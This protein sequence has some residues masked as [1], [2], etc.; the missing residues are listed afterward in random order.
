MLREKKDHYE[1]REKN[2]FPTFS[3]IKHGKAQQ[4]EENIKKLLQHNKQY[5]SRDIFQQIEKSGRKINGINAESNNFELSHLL[6]TQ[7]IQPLPNIFLNWGQ[8]KEIDVVSFESLSTFFYDI[9]Y[10]GSDD[11]YLYDESFS[12]IVYITHYGAVLILKCSNSEQLHF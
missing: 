3:T 1:S 5:E 10:P 4:N 12:W 6:D 2:K 8:F 7:N 9:W 11:I